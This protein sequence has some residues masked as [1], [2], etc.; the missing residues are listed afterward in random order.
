MGIRRGASSL[1]ISVFLVSAP[2][3]S[4]N[5]K[6]PFASVSTGQCKELAMRLAAFTDAFRKKDWD[7]LYDLVAD[8]NKT[9]N[10]GKRLGRKTFARE[11]EGGD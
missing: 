8:T 1:A 11:M 9:R 10:D 2:V 5:A 6:S 3:Y 7:A 4:Q